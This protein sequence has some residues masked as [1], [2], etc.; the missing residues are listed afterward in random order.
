MS[1]SLKT[2]SAKKV[3]NQKCSLLA[4]T[5]AV[6]IGG[7]VVGCAVARRLALGGIS[8]ILLEKASDILDGASKGNSA[9]L[10]T[11]FDAPE[12]SLELECVRNG[13]REYLKIRKSLN[14]P[15]LKT[16]ALIAAW[17]QD[18]EERLPEILE[19][20]V[21]NGIEDLRQLSRPEILVMEPNISEKIRAAIAVPNEFVIDPWSAPLAYLTQAVANGG[22]VFVNTEVKGGEFF[23]DHWILQTNCGSI[24]AKHVI[25]CAGLFGDLVDKVVLG[26]SEFTIKPRKGQFVVFDKSAGSLVR[27]IVFPV[28]TERTKGIVIFP[29]IFG[30][31]AVGPTAEDQESRNDASV[32]KVILKSLHAQAIS[33]IPALTNIPVTA[34]YAGIRPASE[35]K[36]YR[37]VNDTERNWITL[38]G[39]RSTGLTAA[40]GLAQYV[41]KLLEKR[42]AK[43]KKLSRPVVPFVPN[44]AEH[45]PRDWQ[46]SGYGEIVCHCEMVTQREI[47]EALKSQVPATNLGGL[48]RRTRATMGRCQGFY[49]SARLAELTEGRFSESLAIRTSNG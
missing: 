42:G 29:T 18:E 24:K 48:K 12:G 20:A 46:S 21:N 11:G 8:V 31:L 33:R 4:D 30:N 14:L 40:L 1:N 23:G 41:Q 22:H 37:I 39:I 43:F 10:H 47:Y 7:G 32:D 35:K 34:T 45:L 38:G 49:C 3:D 19:K 9:I 26:Q 36:E 5:D 13:Y 25:N 16:G 27:S 15:L 2:K 6:I 44:L 28:P 17:T